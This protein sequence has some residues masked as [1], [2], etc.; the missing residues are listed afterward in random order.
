MRWSATDIDTSSG[1]VGIPIHRLGKAGGQA[2]GHSISL[3]SD[4][5]KIGGATCRRNSPGNHD[6]EAQA[7]V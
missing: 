5:N 6:A 3:V 4:M 7:Y 1:L 2:E